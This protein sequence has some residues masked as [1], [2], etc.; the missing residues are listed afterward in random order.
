[1]A[2]TTAQTS[3]QFD[4]D[5]FLLDPDAWDETVASEIARRDGLGELTPGHWRVIRC[6]R[7]DYERLH[8]PMTMRHICHEQN[9]DPHCVQDLFGSNPKELWRIAGLPNPGEEAKTYM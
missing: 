1:M 3:L 8:A 6:L 9:L 7:E 4:P 5:G 2:A